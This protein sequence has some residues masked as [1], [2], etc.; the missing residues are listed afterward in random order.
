M[1]TAEAFVENPQ[2]MKIFAPKSTYSRIYRTGDLVSYGPDGSIHYIGR[3]DNQVKLA[4]QRMELGEIEH[5]LQADERVRQAVVIMPKSG[6]G[7]RKLTA[8]VSLR[9]GIVGAGTLK[10]PWN[11]PQIGR[12][13]CRERVF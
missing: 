2:F 12:A 3:K 4:G 11:S 6:P 5:H 10:E 13:S 7:K 8:V 1:K 9:Q